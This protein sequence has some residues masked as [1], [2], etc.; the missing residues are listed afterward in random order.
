MGFLFMRF[1][2][3]DAEKRLRP[4]G[5]QAAVRRGRSRQSNKEVPLDASEDHFEI[6]QVAH[7]GDGWMLHAGDPI[8]YANL[9][10]S[11]WQSHL[12]AYG[13]LY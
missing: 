11:Y 5:R 4:S 10:S 1:F 3:S 13:K 9:N 6:P 12:Y 2:A 7:V 8:G